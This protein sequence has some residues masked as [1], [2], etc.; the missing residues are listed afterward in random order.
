MARLVNVVSGCITQSLDVKAGQRFIVMARCKVEGAPCNPSLGFFFRNSKGMGLW[1]IQCSVPFT[2]DLGDGWM[3]LNVP[4]TVPSGRDIT[5]L[6]VTVGTGMAK[7]IEGD[8]GTL[9]DDIEL[10]P[11]KCPWEK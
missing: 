5:S 8:K 1:D 10:H 3:G 6:T 11:V 4:I 9:F 2:I 7:Q